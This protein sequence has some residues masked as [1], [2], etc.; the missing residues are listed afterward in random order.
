MI[1]AEVFILGAGVAGSCAALNLAPLHRTVVVDRATHPRGRLVESL[2]S[3]AGQVLADMGLLQAFLAE[4]H[5]RWQV[6]RSIWGGPHVAEEDLLRDPDGLGWQL[7]RPRFGEWLRS[8]ALAR[9]TTVVAP[10]RLET[11]EGGHDV[12][13]RVRLITPAGPMEVLAGVLVDAAGRSAP[14][15]ARLGAR[16]R[17]S[18]RLV[19]GWIEGIDRREADSAAR[20]SE[21]YLEAASEGWWYSAA[22][23]RGRLLAFYTDADL[24]FAPLAADP[25]QLLGA[26][27]HH[28]TGLGDLLAEVGFEP[29][30]AHGFTA[31]HSAT[32]SPCFGGGWLAAGD[33]AISFDPVSSQGLLTAL[34]TGLAAAEA[35]HRH[36]AGVT[37]PAADYARMVATLAHRYRDNLRDCYAAETRWPSS[38]FWARR[39]PSAWSAAC[40]AHRDG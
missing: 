34:V 21:T 36:L 4:D 23:R 38:P 40:A 27:R 12:G 39:H 11:V 18:D 7:D 20:R 14:L 2:P 37:D 3:A 31:A 25:A 10:A 32:L 22:V 33:A 6:R 9:G 13:W 24:P 26:A 19:C 35:A 8:V 15:G 16:R 1:D 30:P 17:R 29:Q 5:D 28:T